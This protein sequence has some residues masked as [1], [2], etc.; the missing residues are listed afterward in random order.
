M[1]PAVLLSWWS[2]LVQKLKLADET[3]RKGNDSQG[4]MAGG[5]IWCRSSSW[6]EMMRQA[7]RAVTDSA[8]QLVV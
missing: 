1:S 6:H 4:C 7:G 2:Y 5:M 3:S 8:A